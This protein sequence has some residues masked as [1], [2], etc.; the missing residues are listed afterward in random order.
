MGIIDMGMSASVIRNIVIISG[1]GDFGK[2]VS[3]LR[4]RIYCTRSFMAL[5]MMEEKK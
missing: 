5:V 1:Y 2:T 3:S 4:L